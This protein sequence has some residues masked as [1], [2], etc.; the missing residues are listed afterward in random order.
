MNTIGIISE[1]NPF[2]K[3]HAYQ[4]EQLNTMHP[5][6]I[7]IAIMSGSFV[8]RGEPAYFSKFDRSRWAILSGVDVVIELPIIYSLGSAEIFSTGAIRLMKALHINAI[9]F[10]TEVDD[11]PLLKQAAALMNSLE[12]QILIRKELQKYN[13]LEQKNLFEKVK[14]KFSKTT[15][16]E[17]A[18]FMFDYIGDNI[19]NSASLT[20][21]R[22]QWIEVL[23]P[24]EG[25]KL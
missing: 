11:S 10:G 21:L 19:L 6:S 2:H 15:T 14:E 13:I 24:S 12:C 9:S 4:L 22:R 3:G 16:Q 8:Q 7:R 25:G 20:H 18:E 5:D 1:Y 23:F 17:E